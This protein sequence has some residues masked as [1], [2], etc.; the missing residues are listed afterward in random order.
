MADRNLA[1]SQTGV[2]LLLLLLL[3]RQRSSAVA[4]SVDSRDD[5]R[6]VRAPDGNSLQRRNNYS[7]TR[8]LRTPR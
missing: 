3:L 6:A 8:Q 1:T 2:L 7:A 4:A 5:N